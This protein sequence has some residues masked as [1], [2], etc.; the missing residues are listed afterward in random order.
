MVEQYFVSS[1]CRHWGVDE[2]QRNFAAGCFES[3][4]FQCM[5][6]VCVSFR[7]V[8]VASQALCIAMSHLKVG[9]E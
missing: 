9:W 3:H 7:K 2:R 5:W 1:Q 6:D 8:P 4:S